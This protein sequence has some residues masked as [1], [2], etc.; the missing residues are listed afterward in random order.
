VVSPPFIHSSTA[1]SQE[2]YLPYHWL[3]MGELLLTA[4]GDD[5]PNSSQVRGLL[6]DLR[7][8]RLSKLRN[9]IE[10]LQGGGVVN[11]MGVGAME[12]ATERGFVVGVVG[13]LRALGESR[14]AK[15]REDEA[16]A[17]EGDGDDDDGSDM[18]L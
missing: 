12:V 11:L 13:G 10:H 1:D 2:G 15:R 16:E 17:A 14:E 6:R 7:E 3:E 9:G 4:C 5:I 8:V 18:E